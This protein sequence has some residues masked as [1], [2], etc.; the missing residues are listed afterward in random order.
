MRGRAGEEMPRGLW[1]LGVL[2]ALCSVV[3][4]STVLPPG[5]LH[6]SGSRKYG[7]GGLNLRLRGGAIY[8]ENA[9][10][11]DM[12]KLPKDKT[13]AKMRRKQP[14]SAIEL[15]MIEFLF[16][17]H[18]D[19]LPMLKYLH[20]MSVTEMAMSDSG[21]RA[22]IMFLPYVEIEEYRKIGA[23][24]SLLFSETGI[25]YDVARRHGC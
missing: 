9:E 4:P 18:K 14:P 1:R 12:L 7:G 17:L 19:G 15:E 8:E 22:I 11:L 20:I 10:A 6:L 13:G 3:D 21:E 2:L 16:G 5:V 24:E 23:P 25:F